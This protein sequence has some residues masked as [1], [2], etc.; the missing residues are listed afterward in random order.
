MGMLCLSA[1][2]CLSDG[3]AYSKGTSLRRTLLPLDAAKNFK[4]IGQFIYN[5][6]GRNR[7]SE[8]MFVYRCIC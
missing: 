3:C 5:P 4:E 7:T 8:T 1:S 2:L 6:C